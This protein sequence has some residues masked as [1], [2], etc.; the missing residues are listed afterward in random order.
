MESGAFE[1]KSDTDV[2]YFTV[3]IIL[4]MKSAASVELVNLKE[5]FA[6]MSMYGQSKNHFRSIIPISANAAEVH[7]SGSIHNVG[8]YEAGRWVSAVFMFVIQR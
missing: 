1:F 2:I 7:F 5:C 6:R 3:V 8:Y 4:C